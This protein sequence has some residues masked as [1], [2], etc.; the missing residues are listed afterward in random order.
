MQCCNLEQEIGTHRVAFV[1]LLAFGSLCA[2]RSETLGW[3]VLSQTTLWPN[4]RFI[5]RCVPNNETMLFGKTR[6]AA[7]E[8]KSRS[9]KVTYWT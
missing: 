5:L 9:G 6:H 7:R 3:H 2:L 4:F 1:S 8:A